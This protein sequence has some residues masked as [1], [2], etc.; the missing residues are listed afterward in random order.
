MVH[1]FLLRKYGLAKNDLKAILGYQL[2][3]VRL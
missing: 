1:S 3:S 2:Q